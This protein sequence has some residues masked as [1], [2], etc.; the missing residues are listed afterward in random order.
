[1]PLRACLA[2]RTKSAQAVLAM[3]A[4]SSPASP[5]PS[6]PRMTAACRVTP[7]LPCQ[8]PVGRNAPRQVFPA[9]PCQACPACSCPFH[10]HPGLPCLPCQKKGGGRLLSP[11]PEPLLHRSDGDYFLVLGAPTTW[12]MPWLS[13]DVCCGRRSPMPQ[14]MPAM[15]SRLTSSTRPMNPALYRMRNVA[16]HVSKYGR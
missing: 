11:H 8:Y 16:P 1:M 7:C 6:W 12:N 13:P 5:I 3:P 15:L 4:N 10:L 2:N 14:A 9:G